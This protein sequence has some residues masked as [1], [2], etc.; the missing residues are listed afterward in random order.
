MIPSFV[1]T[2]I[3]STYF[4]TERT[5]SGRLDCLRLPSIYI[6]REN[7]DGLF[8]FGVDLG[9]IH[10][11]TGN[12]T[13]QTRYEWTFNHL[14]FLPRHPWPNSREHSVQCTSLY[15]C[16]SLPTYLCSA[17]L[18]NLSWYIPRARCLPPTWHN[19]IIYSIETI[20]ECRH[21]RV[22]NLTSHPNLFL[23]SK[24]TLSN[25]SHAWPLE[26]FAVMTSYQSIIYLRL[27]DVSPTPRLS[28]WLVGFSSQAI[29][30]HGTVFPP[31]FHPRWPV[32]ALKCQ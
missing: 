28:L 27:A 25:M 1:F 17:T 32:N 8:R 16:T 10:V 6:P 12:D 11:S 2:I 13:L 22:S 19:R 14:F 7:V 31:P 5:A 20:V 30:R 4:L 23:W 29:W 21:S 26:P 18:P 9:T 15:Q 24:R 3:T